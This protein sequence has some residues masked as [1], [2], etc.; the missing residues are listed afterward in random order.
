MI[1]LSPP[2]PNVDFFLLPHTKTPFTLQNSTVITTANLFERTVVNE[3]PNETALSLRYPSIEDRYGKCS[4]FEWPQT[5]LPDLEKIF[6]NPFHFTTVNSS[7]LRHIRHKSHPS[8]KKDKVSYLWGLLVPVATL[9]T[10]NV[11]AT[12]KNF[13]SKL[14]KSSL[15]ERKIEPLPISK[16]ESPET[17]TAPP[18]RPDASKST[19]L[20]LSSSLS[21]TPSPSP[22]IEKKD[23]SS[24]SNEDD[25]QSFSLASSSSSPLP[26]HLLSQSD[27]PLYYRGQSEALSSSVDSGC[28]TT[29][30]DDFKALQQKAQESLTHTDPPTMNQSGQSLSLSSSWLNCSVGSLSNSEPYNNPFERLSFSETPKRLSYGIEFIPAEIFRPVQISHFRL[31]STSNPDIHHKQPEQSSTNSSMNSLAAY[32]EFFRAETVD[33]KDLSPILDN[34]SSNGYQINTQILL[35]YLLEVARKNNITSWDDVNSCHFHLID[36]GKILSLNVRLNK[37]DEETV[38][39]Q[40]TKT[41][42]KQLKNLPFNDSQ[43]NQPPQLDTS[44]VVQGSLPEAFRKLNSFSLCQNGVTKIIDEPIEDLSHLT[45]ELSRILGNHPEDNWLAGITIIEALA[46]QAAKDTQ[47]TWEDISSFTFH[48]ERV[49]FFSYFICCHCKRL[50]RDGLRESRVIS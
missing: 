26:A 12:I 16:N 27:G 35:E 6:S 5:P 4:P 23:P 36:T 43:V 9:M 38:F 29:I 17:Y 21:K 33:F 30:C 48:V 42:Y 14:T 20:L 11:L 50:D 39:F 45:K 3:T 10:L 13:F 2:L 47:K 44:K 32:E 22:S 1:S 49:F 34:F 46:R 7:L 19:S 15:N 37:D 41:F 18:P 40:E 28:T 24:S 31:K 25:P 8:P